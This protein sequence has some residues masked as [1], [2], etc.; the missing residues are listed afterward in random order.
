MRH[1]TFRALPRAIIALALLLVG[2]GCRAPEGTTPGETVRASMSILCTT[3]PV[4]LFA[5]EVCEGTGLTLERLLPASAGCPHEYVMSMQDRGLVEGADVLL[6]N[7]LGL[8]ATILDAAKAARPD[9][10]ILTATEG[11]GDLLPAGDGPHEHKHSEEHHPE[12]WNPHLFASPA[13]AAGMVRTI[14]RGLATVAPDKA[15]VLKRNAERYA[16]RLE[17]LAREMGKGVSGLRNRTIVTQHNVF[18]YLAADLGLQV[19]AVVYAHPGEALSAAEVREIVE[20]AR[21]ARAGAVFT[22][23]QYPE[24]IG[25]TIARELGVPAEKLNPVASGP[26]DPPRGYYEQ[27]M[28]ENLRTL[29]RVLGAKH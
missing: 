26:E 7:G 8:D 9:L 6:A 15:A 28:R 19:A 17:D 4:W 21:R 29:V 10:R 27:V 3:Y 14:A 23:P 2:G 5:R 22:E 16:S 24:A 11:I 1:R 25:R 13:R 20:A 18:D 12:E